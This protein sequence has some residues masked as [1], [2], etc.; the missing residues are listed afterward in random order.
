MVVE[1]ELADGVTATLGTKLVAEEIEDDVGAITTPIYQQQL[2][3]SLRAR[4]I[5][6]RGSLTPP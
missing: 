4:S 1:A 5:G 6:T 2:S 3:H